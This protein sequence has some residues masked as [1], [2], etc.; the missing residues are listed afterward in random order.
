MGQ[1]WISKSSRTPSWVLTS[2]CR[3]ETAGREKSR[4]AFW[5]LRHSFYRV[6]ISADLLLVELDPV[7]T[8]PTHTRRGLRGV[9]RCGNHI[10][11]TTRDLF[12]FTC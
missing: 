8:E 10:I 3:N 2:S 7:G 5:Q 12:V 11:D 9:T 6:T 4:I 1:V